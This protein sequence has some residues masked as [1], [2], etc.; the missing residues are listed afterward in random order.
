MALL[1]RKDLE[2]KRP[3]AYTETDV[4]HPDAAKAAVGETVTIRLRAM[5]GGEWIDLIRSLRKA[6]GEPDEFRNRNYTQLV[7]AFCLVDEEGK[8]I[9]TDDDLN[10]SW[11]K[12]QSKA[13]VTSAIDAAMSFSGLASDAED[14]RKNLPT[15]GGS[16]NSTASPPGSD[17]EPPAILSTTLD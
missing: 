1:T 9:L 6:N 10:T 8:R 13:F 15:T 17:I 12:T 16:D 3:R 4:P 2:Q 14:Q 5:F 11:W 7:L